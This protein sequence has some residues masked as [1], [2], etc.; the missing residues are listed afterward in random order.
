MTPMEGLLL[1]D[2]PSGPTSHDIV[3]MVRRYTS[4]Q[5]V[6]HTGTLD[7]FAT[8]LLPLC[9]GRATRLSRFLTM[10]RKRYTG[11]M[12]L[13]VSTD[14]YDGEGEVTAIREIPDLDADRLRRIASR[15]TGRFMQTPPSYSARKILGRP[16]HR[17]AR[18][19][20]QVALTPTEVTISRLEISMVT[21]EVLRFEAET[22]PG[23]YIRS[24]AHDLGDALGC[25]AHLVELRRLA[26]GNL[27]VEM[28]HGMR[29]IRDRWESGTLAEI[30]T[31]LAKID[32]GLPSVTATDR[33]AQALRTGR[34]LSTRELVEPQKV[35]VSMPVRIIDEAGNLLAVALADA[36]P[37]T[38]VTLRP[39]VVLV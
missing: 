29:E 3:A 17:L 16:M 13:G 32:L 27:R 18:Q 15:F 4:G 37:A 34:A 12:R 1:V 22:S 10:G 8:G 6:G 19:G 2:K 33:G 31:P 36:G 24:L 30:V 20:K 5:R 38:D 25:G 23:T 9:I 26:S 28:A 7:P 11:R 39:H 35:E 21:P 14:T